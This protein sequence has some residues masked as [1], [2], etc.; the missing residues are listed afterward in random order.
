MLI[1]EAQDTNALPAEI[2]RSFFIVFILV[3]V[4]CAIE[5]YSKSALRTIEVKNERPDTLLTTKFQTTD[6]TTF[7][8]TPKCSLGGGHVISQ[9]FAKRSLF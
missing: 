9:S 2:F 1:T 4:A 6:S 5:F 7:Q 3:I 8:G